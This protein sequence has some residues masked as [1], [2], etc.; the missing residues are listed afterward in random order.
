MHDLNSSQ[1]QATA[2]ASV[3]SLNNS[4]LKSRGI[5]LNSNRV[6]SGIKHILSDP[7]LLLP[8]EV[9]QGKSLKVVITEVG[10]CGHFWCS[11]DDDSH[12]NTLKFIHDLLNHVPKKSSEKT[13]SNEAATAI[14]YPLVL[15]NQNEI[16]EDA[17]CVS[18]YV[19]ANSEA[20]YRA[21]ILH[22]DRVNCQVEIVYVDYG[23]KEIKK[24]DQIFKCTQE[25]ME[26]PF[27]AL[28]CRLVNI[29]PSL[30]TNPNGVW[31]LKANQAFKV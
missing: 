17:L 18:Q 21:R 22:V 31:I 7:R 23:N 2:T 26:Y 20:L 16:K 11:I 10:E 1:N 28:E 3:S 30:I 13:T 6:S 29:K 12:F 4:L 15:M 24:Y 14:R 19:D 8:A 25:L 27:Q 9:D 5:Q